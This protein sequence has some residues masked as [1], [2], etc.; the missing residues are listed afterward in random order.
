MSETTTEPIAVSSILLNPKN[1]RH[2]PV[3]SQEECIRELLREPKDRDYMF[4]LATDIAG[5]GLDPSSLP[6]VEPKGKQWRV[7][8]GNRRLACLKAMSNSDTIPDVEGV[9]ERQ[10]KAYRK[11][12]ADLGEASALPEDLLCVVTTDKESSDHWIT[13]KHTGVGEHRGA[14]TVEWD[15]SGKV[16]HRNSLG[17]GATAGRASSEQSGRA[18]LLLD[19]LREEFEDDAE[20]ISLVEKAMAKG[21]STLG[22]VLIKP[23]NRLR[24]GIEI[25]GQ[26]VRWTVTPAALRATMI[27]VLTDLNT[28]S[29]N[30]RTVNTADNV[31]DYLDRIHDELPRA[32]ER[33]ETPRSP[34][35]GG[36][37]TSASGTGDAAK[38]AATRA[39]RAKQPPR[40]PYTGLKLPNASSKTRA[41]LDEMQKL[42]F[43]QH[44]NTI[45]ILTRV[46][47]DLFCNDVIQ[48]LKLK[49]KSTLA[50]NL[51]TCLRLIDPD[52]G[53]PLKRRAHVAVWNGLETETGELSVES[54][55]LY[56][57]RKAATGT[58]QVARVQCEHYEKLF[59]A[60]DAHVTANL[61]TK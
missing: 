57:H 55:H 39:R 27:R 38:E 20:V 16:R 13:L 56:L 50:D 51:R 46:L 53:V 33:T 18:V 15:P 11:K 43:D 48:E 35:R 58:E 61:G 47:I 40:K 52:S 30:S 37:N 44:P 26:V 60:L 19:A 54:M 7:L 9:T 45:V 28:P 59:T 49:E 23:E 17:A 25:E 2:D 24:L 14:G 5:R 12:F 34:T 1:F 36:G 21:T 22:R 3:E 10:M 41:V 31:V 4:N 29:L 6:I 32:A 42:R 8:E